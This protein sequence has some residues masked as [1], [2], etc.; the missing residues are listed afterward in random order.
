MLSADSSMALC[1]CWHKI[2]LPI[3]LV[4]DLE[5]FQHNPQVKNH[6][7]DVFDGLDVGVPSPAEAKATLSSS[8]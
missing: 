3:N 6:I 2:P 8:D 1:N 4:S 5:A 7:G